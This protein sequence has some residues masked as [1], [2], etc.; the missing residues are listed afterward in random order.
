VML[1]IQLHDSTSSF[2]TVPLQKRQAIK[3]SLD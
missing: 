1:S 2:A 3:R